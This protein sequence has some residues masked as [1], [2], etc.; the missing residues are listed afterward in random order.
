MGEGGTIDLSFSSTKNL[1]I[2]FPAQHLGSKAKVELRS[3]ERSV[4]PLLDG[5]PTQQGSSPYTYNIETANGPF[6][7][8]DLSKR[9]GYFLPVWP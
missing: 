4:H 9:M 3:S 1:E 8:R 5:T 2:K 7:P 6:L